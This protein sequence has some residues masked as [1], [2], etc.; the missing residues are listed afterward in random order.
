MRPQAR[1]GKR[2]RILVSRVSKSQIPALSAVNQFTIELSLASHTS[3]HLRFWLLCYHPLIALLIAYSLDFSS[4]QLISY[5]IFPPIPHDSP[6]TF[7]GS[8]HH[9]PQASQSHGALNLRHTAIT[10]RTAPIM[11]Q[12]FRKDTIKLTCLDDLDPSDHWGAVLRL[13]PN[14]KD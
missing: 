7:H 6:S 5:Y 10:L 3:P 9:S 11:T 12:E 1:L 2:T 13:G 14:L 8:F 4:Y